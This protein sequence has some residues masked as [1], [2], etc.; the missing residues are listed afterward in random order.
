[1]SIPA[2]E[3]FPGFSRRPDSP[4]LYVL[5][6]REDGEP[7]YG[8]GWAQTHPPDTNRAG[9]TIGASYPAASLEEHGFRVCPRC[10][11]DGVSGWDE[12]EQDIPCDYCSG[13]VI[14]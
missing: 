2:H 9:I 1:M 5:P 3:L 12:K 7:G 4:E 13:G 8:K 11:G 10:D 14:Q 6:R